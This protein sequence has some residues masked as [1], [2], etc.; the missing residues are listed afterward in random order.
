MQRRTEMAKWIA[1]AEQESDDDEER[2]SRTIDSVR[3]WYGSGNQLLYGFNQFVG[4][5]SRRVPD[6]PKFGPCHRSRGGPDER[7][8]RDT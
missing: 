8:E 1:E 6:V 5:A 2:T 3:K 7:S 4:H